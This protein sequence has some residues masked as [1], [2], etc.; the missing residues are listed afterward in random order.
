MFF[1]HHSWK[2]FQNSTFLFFFSTLL[3]RQKQGRMSQWWPLNLTIK[4]SHSK[5]N[6]PRAKQN[7]GGWGNRLGFSS[8]RLDCL[9]CLAESHGISESGRQGS[10][11][12][13][14]CNTLRNLK[15]C[16]NIPQKHFSSLCFLTAREQKAQN[17]K[18]VQ[19]T[20]NKSICGA[21]LL[22]LFVFSQYVENGLPELY[23]HSTLCCNSSA[24][25]CMLVKIFISELGLSLHH[26][27]H[28]M[29]AWCA[30]DVR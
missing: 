20:F 3:I 1:L 10:Q 18:G 4:T 5:E 7:L 27:R 25:T 24:L 26:W 29:G 15:S 23:L 6:S 17:T 9:L 13:F 22:S 16:D 19:P 2:L 8:R 30:L 11:R 21:P 12:S 14:W 28:L